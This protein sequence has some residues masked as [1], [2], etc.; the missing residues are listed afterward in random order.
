VLQGAREAFAEHGFNGATVRDIAA[1]A[2]VDPSLVVQFF[3]SK[4][5]VFAAAM[6]LP[7]DTEA[8]VAGLLRGPRSALG[9]RMV[10]TFLTLWDHP[11]TGGRLLALLRS[12]ATHDAAAQRLRE[13]IESGIL[14]PLAR[15]LDAPDAQLRAALV[16]AHLVGLGFARYVL[17]IE[18]LASEPADSL[19]R[20]MGPT[21]QRYLTDPL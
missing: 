19:E 11:D 9:A 2:G 14:G 8:V 16:G 3:G 13:L 15:A 7:F 10:R 6:E 18:P 4:E 12:A 17:R 5:S 1:R 21:I 20:R